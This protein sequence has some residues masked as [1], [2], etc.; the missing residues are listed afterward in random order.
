MPTRLM[1][2]ILCFTAEEIWQALRGRREP[3]DAGFTATKN[4]LARLHFPLWLVS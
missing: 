2:P 4:T 1:A 3:G